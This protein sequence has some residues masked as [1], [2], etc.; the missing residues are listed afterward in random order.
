MVLG[1]DGVKGLE[2][3]KSGKS[4]VKPDVVPP[5]HGDE[6]AEPH[7]GDFMADSSSV[8]HG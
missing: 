8:S 7:V 1:M 3:H 2:F 5:G 4:F 6:V